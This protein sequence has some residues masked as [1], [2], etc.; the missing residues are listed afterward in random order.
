MGVPEAEKARIIGD[1]FATHDEAFFAG[2]FTVLDE[3][4]LRSRPFPT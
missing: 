4:N 1:V 3:R 2:H